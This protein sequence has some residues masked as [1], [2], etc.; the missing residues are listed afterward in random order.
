MTPLEI[1]NTFI[2]ALERKDISA[3]MALVSE[4]CEYDNVT[5]VKVF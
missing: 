2:Q 1:V 5:L 4:N 3:A